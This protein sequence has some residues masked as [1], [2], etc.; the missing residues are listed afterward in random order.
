MQ[1]RGRLEGLRVVV[2][3]GKDWLIMK[4]FGEEK[5][6]AFVLAPYEALYLVEKG[7]L[8]VE[9]NGKALSAE[10]LRSRFQEADP[11]FHIKY[12]VYKDVRERGYVIKTGFKFGGHFRVYPR[13]KKPGEAHT[14]FVIWVIPEERLLSPEEIARFVRLAR[15]IRTTALLAFVDAEDDVVYYKIEREEL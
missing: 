1:A 2:D 13:G 3:E 15:N 7:K 12:V 5:K 9:E 4:G 11:N 6:D 14:K 10:E 8:E